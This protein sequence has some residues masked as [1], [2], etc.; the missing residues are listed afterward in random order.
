MEDKSSPKP[1]NQSEIQLLY[2]ELGVFSGQVID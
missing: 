2:G 1:K